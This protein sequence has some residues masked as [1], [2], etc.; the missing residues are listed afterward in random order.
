MQARKIKRQLDLPA[1]ADTAADGVSAGETAPDTRGAVPLTKTPPGGGADSAENLDLQR[2]ISTANLQRPQ[3]NAAPLAPSVPLVVTG[4]VQHLA[5]PPSQHPAMPQAIATGIP[6]GQPAAFMHPASAMQPTAQHPAA[7]QT[8]VIC[9]TTA[10]QWGES[11]ATIAKLESE[12][13]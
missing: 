5:A 2:A 12:Q 11:M 4:A 6:V 7:V 3:A 8:V 1:S 10:T 13:V 9:A